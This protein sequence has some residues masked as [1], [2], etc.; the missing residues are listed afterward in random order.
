MG[1]PQQT[2]MLSS[3][4]RNYLR[5]VYQNSVLYYPGLDFASW[6]TNTILDYSGNKNHGTI[7]GA[8][9]TRLPSGLWVLDYDGSNDLISGGSGA[10]LDNIAA[11]TAMTWIKP[12]TLG[13]GAA[14]RIM[15][16]AQW[17]FYLDTGNTLRFL[18]DHA[19]TDLTKVSNNNAITFGIR[20]FVAVTWDGSTAHANVHL[21]VNG[22][23]VG[24]SGTDAV[25]ARADDSA[26]TLYIGNVAAANRAFDGWIGLPRI[27]SSVL[28]ASQI[29]AIYNQEQRYL[30]PFGSLPYA[31]PSTAVLY[32]PGF[33]AGGIYDIDH[34]GYSYHG[35]ISGAVWTQTGY[36]L[37][38]LDFDGVD[39]LENCGSGASLDNLAAFTAIA[40]IKPDT[41]GEGGAARI[42][43]KASNTDT[44][45]WLLYID[46]T[47]SLR[48]L[49]DH[50][51]TDLT[52]ISN[53]NAITLGAAQM[54]VI[55]WDGTADRT[56]ACLYVNGVEVT[57]SGG[58]AD[59]VGARVDD[60]AS[61]LTIGNRAD[62]SRTFDG[63]IG[64]KVIIP[65]VWSAAQILAFYNQTR[66]SFGL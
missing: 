25:D 29:L 19:T 27:I 62:G 23:D 48:F 17:L 66:G 3:G 44:A 16:K 42:F 28:S 41:M 31:I 1:L 26:S 65:S 11:F 34:S 2:I 6:Y 37:W 30:A 61:L 59:A 43:H 58:G 47:S 49:V 51:T 55:T 53:N 38:V 18:V 39:D 52:R 9:P 15:D 46:G 13:G 40:W 60:A 36:G 10:S 57:Y 8:I 32:L 22:V 20:Q 45:G 64:L 56:H 12:D 54:V 63:W 21:Y 5:R 14:G 24:F 4:L 33:P 50:A 7:T 35:T